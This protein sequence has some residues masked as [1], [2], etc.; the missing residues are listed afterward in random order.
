[1]LLRAHAASVTHP[2]PPQSSPRLHGCGVSSP[3]PRPHTQTK[4]FLHRFP[5]RERRRQ[6]RRA[7]SGGEHDARWGGGRRDASVRSFPPSLCPT[8]QKANLF[9]PSGGGLKIFGRLEEPMDGSKAAWE[10]MNLLLYFPETIRRDLEPFCPSLLSL[11]L[12]KR[13]ISSSIFFFEAARNISG[14]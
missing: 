11:V 5:E 14:P 6:L 7:R 2:P 1:M 9:P 3:P 4:R 10:K 12:N 8:S 13:G